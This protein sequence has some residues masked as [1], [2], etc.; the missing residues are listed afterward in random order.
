M[1]TEAAVWFNFWSV[2]DTYADRNMECVGKRTVT[3]HENKKLMGVQA[4]LPWD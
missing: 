1:A 4:S 2:L 3:V